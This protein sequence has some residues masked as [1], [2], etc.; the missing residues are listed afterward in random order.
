[1]AELVAIVTDLDT[2]ADA[3]V[4]LYNV[5]K[6]RDYLPF[7][8]FDL[9]AMNKGNRDTTTGL[10]KSLYEYINNSDNIQW[11]TNIPKYAIHLGGGVIF[12][13]DIYSCQ[14]RF[15]PPRFGPGYG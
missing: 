6:S 13:P 11:A 4:E 12:N 14:P 7:I 8:E 3:E 10:C 9:E 15:V 5:L 2:V 1:M